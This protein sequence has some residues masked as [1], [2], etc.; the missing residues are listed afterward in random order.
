MSSN[1]SHPGKRHP[2]R[3]Y[4]YTLPRLSSLQS[5]VGAL[6]SSR[7]PLGLVLLTYVPVQSN[8]LVDENGRALLT[9]FGLAILANAD[10]LT[11]IIPMRGTI[12]WM[13]P[14]LLGT[15]DTTIESRYITPSNN[16]WA[17][18][19]VIWEV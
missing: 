15:G 10:D 2:P 11:A 5:Q 3:T 4:T 14:E 9:N 16:I 12:R 6:T 13:S 17:L 1:E 19:I 18:G 8:V 7:P